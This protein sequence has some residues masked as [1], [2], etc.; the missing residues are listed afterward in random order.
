MAFNSLHFLLFFPVVCIL[1]FLLPLRVRW[2]WLLLASYYFYMSWNA[3]YALLILTSSVVTYCSGLVIHR[4]AV[5]WKRRSVLAL[6]F[7]VNL[8]I[9]I[10]F[11]YGNFIIDN[12]NGL[13]D[14]FSAGR[15]YG[16]FDLLLPVGISFY[17]FQALSYTMDVYR[18]KIA[19]ETNFFRYALFVSFSRNWSP[20]PSSG[21]RICCR[22]SGS[23]TSSIG[24]GFGTACI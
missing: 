24:R 21:Q 7:L 18:G 15:H 23:S 14:V 3:S 13:L 1:Y 20:A 4:V 17:T 22:R 19:A 11:K 5:Q 10:F 9:L 16:H 6:C 12:A 8:S 2:G